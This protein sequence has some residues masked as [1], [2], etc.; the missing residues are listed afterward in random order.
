M[1]GRGERTPEIEILDLKTHSIKFKLSK[2]DLSVA[3]ALR[4]TMISQVPT[5]AIDLVM[6]QEN[7]SVLHDEFLAHRL[8]LI[9]LVSTRVKELEFY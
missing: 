5:M 3:N 6:I 9:P 8:G 4:R 1:Y 2:C 7:T